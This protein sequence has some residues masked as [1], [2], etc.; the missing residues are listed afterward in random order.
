MIIFAGAEEKSGISL[1]TEGPIQSEALIYI[2]K[3]VTYLH[4][5]AIEEHLQEAWGERTIIIVQ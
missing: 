5:I 1:E 4:N 2:W 3:V